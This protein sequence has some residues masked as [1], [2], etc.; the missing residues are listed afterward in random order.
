MLRRTTELCFSM[1]CG[2][3]AEMGLN[4]YS[5]TVLRATLRRRLDLRRSC[6]EVANGIL[7]K[8]DRWW[9]RMCMSTCT[10][11]ALVFWPMG[12][13]TRQLVLSTRLCCAFFACWELVCA[14]VLVDRG[15]FLSWSQPIPV[16]GQSH[17]PTTSY[18]YTEN[19]FLII[20]KN[21]V[22]KRWC[23]VIS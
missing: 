15:S 17:T 14:I 22:E 11:R 8:E 6:L 2:V 13:F 4:P 3:S 9:R 16:G 10:R 5:N 18:C 1:S 7:H 20:S 19:C 12:S 21:K 23:G